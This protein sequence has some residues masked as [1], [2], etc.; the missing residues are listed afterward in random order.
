MK[1]FFPEIQLQIGV[2]T[3]MIQV[4]SPG[5]LKNITDVATEKMIARP[6]GLP[7]LLLQI[8]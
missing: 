7:N 3:R 5:S 1:L 6:H 4:A 8:N 2:N